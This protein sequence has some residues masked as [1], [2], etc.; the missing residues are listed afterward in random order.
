MSFVLVLSAVISAAFGQFFYKS[1]A[2]MRL[3]LYIVL[4]V[5]F[6]LLSPILNMLSLKFYTVD[7]VYIFT[8]VSIA[9]VVVLSNFYLGEKISYRHWL[10]IVF[11][12]LGV[13]GY[14]L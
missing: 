9:L 12:L 5:L 4:A 6:F 3:K 8:S 10:G 14:G 7:F 2:V 11:I 13:V 1:Y